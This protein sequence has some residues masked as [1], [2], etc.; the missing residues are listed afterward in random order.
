MNSHRATTIDSVKAVTRQRLLIGVVAVMGAFVAQATTPSTLNLKMKAR[1]GYFSERCLKLDRGQQLAYQLSTRHPVEF[2]LH[3]HPDAGDTVFPDRLT[4]KSQ[5]S[6]QIVAQSGGE[7]CFM[8]T[9][10]K[11]Q[12]G[13]FDVVITYEISAP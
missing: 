4:V 11:D 7:Y 3:H 5:H 2:N 8:A 12:P 1:K 9:N 13:A 6:K 10:P